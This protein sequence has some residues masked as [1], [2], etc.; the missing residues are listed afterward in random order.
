MISIIN[1]GINNINSIK[2]CLNKLNIECSVVY[3]PEEVGKGNKIILPGVGSFVIAMQKLEENNWSSFLKKFTQNKKNFLL[4]ICLGMQLLANKSFE[5][6]ESE[7]LKL[8]DCDVKKLSEMNCKKKL[9]HVGWNSIKILKET[10]LFKNIPNYIDFYFVHS[11]SMTMNSSVIA[12]FNYDND[13]VAAVQNKNIFGV[14]FHPEKS[15]TGG[16][17]ILKNFDKIS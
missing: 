1:Y 17:A 13:Y 4:G 14:Q 2:N 8:I 5:E 7:G 9:P 10:P 6:T 15:S 12:E 3:K 16:Q 11:Y